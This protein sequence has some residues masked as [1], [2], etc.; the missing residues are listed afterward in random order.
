[1]TILDIGDN[2]MQSVSAIAESYIKV[3]LQKDSS[4][5]LC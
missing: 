5:P 3:R 4:F 1:V 2:T